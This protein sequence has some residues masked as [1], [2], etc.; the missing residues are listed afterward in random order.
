MWIN[1][2]YL[3]LAALFRSS[4][5]A[6]SPG[7]L[8]VLGYIAAHVLEAMPHAAAMACCQRLMRTGSE[9]LRLWYRVQGT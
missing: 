1:I 3:A 4:H 5:V 6:T 7:C 2:N 8:G 9:V